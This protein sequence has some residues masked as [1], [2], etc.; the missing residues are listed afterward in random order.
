MSTIL[1]KLKSY[2]KTSSPEQIKSDWNE[3]EKYDEIGPTIDEFLDQTIYHHKIEHQEDFWGI[4]SLNDIIT[5]PKF[6]SDFFF[7]LDFLK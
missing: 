5:N 3:F 7:N 6:T 4:N 2:Y 1:E